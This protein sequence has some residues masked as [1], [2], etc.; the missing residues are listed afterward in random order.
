M[1]SAENAR[2][3]ARPTPGLRHWFRPTLADCLFIAL[4]CWLLAFTFA[5]ASAGLLQDAATGFHIRNGEWM[6]THHSIARTDP[7][8]FSQ[9]GWPFLSLEWLSGVI[10]AGLYQ[11]A[12]LKAIVL[13]SAVLITATMLLVVFR[14]LKLGANALAALVV[15]HVC[16][17][18]SSIHFLAR[19]HLFTYFFLAVAMLLL[20][21]DRRRPGRAAWLLVP[22]TA[23]WANLHGGFL[24][25]LVCLGLLTIG[26]GVEA[27]LFAAGE[28]G[29]SNLA[30][31]YGLLTGACGAAACLN[32]WGPALLWRLFVY[33]HQGWMLEIIQ[34]YQPPR[35][36]EA[37]GRYVE[38]LVVAAVLT[39][40]ALLA[41]KQVAAALLIL[42]WVHA[43]LTSV[44]HVP[45][46]AVIAAPWIAAEATRLWR[47]TCGRFRGSSLLKALDG[48][49]RDHAPGLGRL[50]LWPAVFV[51]LAAVA[52]RIPWPADFPASRFP[53]GLVSRHAE[54]ISGSRIFS[55]DAWSDYLTFRFY[56]RQRIFID[57]RVGGF[58]GETICQEYQRLLYARAGWSEL[59][60]KYRIDAALIPAES[61]LASALKL[62]PDWALIERTPQA[63]LFVRARQMPADEA[64]ISTRQHNR[65]AAIRVAP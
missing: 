56:P 32:P 8:S 12:G 21:R 5:G 26:Y 40:A 59:L 25:L 31:R 53:A 20:D 65:H 39:A 4:V 33:L 22:L 27:W 6:L 35:F 52:P 30:R 24:A 64:R 47:E 36:A 54:L 15:A 28:P 37:G 46:L 11:W 45:I 2:R 16:I 29:R 48:I 50:S 49:A 14:M 60:D 23:L 3:G 51:V 55:T 44:R 61:S 18:A 43:S 62:H 10:F 58:F 17:G 7:F 13:F 41:R 19:P 42:A 63:A 57:G 34:E 9:P 1:S 38:L